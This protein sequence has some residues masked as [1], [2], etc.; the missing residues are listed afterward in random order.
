MENGGKYTGSGKVVVAFIRRVAE[1]G[2]VTVVKMVG[3]D[4]LD[5]RRDESLESGI[6]IGGEGGDVG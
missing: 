5:G 4:I 6:L 2:W 1:G 3:R